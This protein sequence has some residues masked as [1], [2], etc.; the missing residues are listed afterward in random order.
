MRKNVL[1]YVKLYINGI[2]PRTIFISL[3]SHYIIIHMEF[4]I[5]PSPH[6]FDIMKSSPQRIHR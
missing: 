4:C 2:V 5:P 1:Y 6:I 3:E